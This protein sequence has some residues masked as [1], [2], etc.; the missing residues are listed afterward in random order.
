MN[1]LKPQIDKKQLNFVLEQSQTHQ[2]A[3][4]I[5]GSGTAN[6]LFLFTSLNV[7]EF[8]LTSYVSEYFKSFHK[9]ALDS[10]IYILIDTKNYVFLYEVY[11]KMPNANVTVSLLC[12]FNQI[13]NNVEF[14]F[15]NNVLFR[16]R[17]LTG[18]HL[19]I[20]YLTNM[21]FFL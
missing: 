10:S 6:W 13:S 7:S 19:K 21:S 11:R 9:I 2:F 20:G 17:D 16:R 14:F 12:K 5:V 1:K 18:V 4:K 3:S 15:G 8:F